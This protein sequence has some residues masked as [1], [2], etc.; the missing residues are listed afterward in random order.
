MVKT[1][2]K[3]LVRVFKKHITRFLSI[4]FM[5]L[6]SVGFVSGIGCSV[7]KINFSLTD[8]YKTQNVSDLIIKST[9][10]AFSDEETAAILARYGEE[11]VNAGASLD[12]ELEI[13]GETR[14]TRLYFFDGEQTVNLQNSKETGDS[15]EAE[16]PARTEQGDNKIKEI[17]LGAEFQRDFKTARRTERRIARSHARF[18]ARLHGD[19]QNYGDGNGNFPAHLC[20]RRRTELP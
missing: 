7:D 5:V 15:P 12:V 8:H 20:K 18:S 14:L 4:V 13:D 10:G 1:Y 3:T 19:A 16:Y 11:H 9:N 2:L 6:I 17:S